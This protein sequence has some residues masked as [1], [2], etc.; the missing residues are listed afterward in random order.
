MTDEPPPELLE[1]IAASF[2]GPPE[3]APDAVKDRYRRALDALRRGKCDECLE[4]VR[5]GPLTLTDTPEGVAIIGNV[6]VEFRHLPGCP[7]STAE[8]KSLALRLDCD[9]ADGWTVIPP[10][11]SEHDI[12]R[13]VEDLELEWPGDA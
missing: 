2:P 1:V 11:S 7:L 12:A 5:A 6:S 9:W 8:L 3:D 10:D 4:R 13:H